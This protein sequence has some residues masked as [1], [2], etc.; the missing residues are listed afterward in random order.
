[1]L[2]LLPQALSA[3]F[4]N[5]CCGFHIRESDELRNQRDPVDCELLGTL[6]ACMKWASVPMFVFHIGA[7][8]SLAGDHICGHG[9]LGDGSHLGVAL[10]QGPARG[11]L[12]VFIL[13]LLAEKVK[14]RIFSAMLTI[15]LDI[16]GKR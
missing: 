12:E 5:C 4:A 14:V 8:V 13:A 7:P 2:P 6:P 3:F 10:D 16:W 15:E 1:M 9:W 11:P